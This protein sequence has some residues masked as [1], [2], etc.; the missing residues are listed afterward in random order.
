[1]GQKDAVITKAVANLD[2][3]EFGLI[4]TVLFFAVVAFFP[5]VEHVVVHFV[6][7]CAEV[8][9]YPQLTMQ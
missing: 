1:L 5:S 7:T 6:M 3:I 9:D 8:T 2:L 4:V